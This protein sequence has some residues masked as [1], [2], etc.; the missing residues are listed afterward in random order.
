LFSFSSS[1]G[2]VPARG[3]VRVIITFNPQQTVN[4]HERVF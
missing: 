4:Y 1:E 3:S 2:V